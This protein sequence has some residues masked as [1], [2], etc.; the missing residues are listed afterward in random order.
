MFWFL[1]KQVA[2]A[3]PP[4]PMMTDAELA[5]ALQVANDRLY[6]SLDYKLDKPWSLIPPVKVRTK[7]MGYGYVEGR[8]RALIV[9]ARVAVCEADDD[10]D[11][12]EHCVLIDGVPTLLILA[13]GRHVSVTVIAERDFLADVFRTAAL[14]MN[15][16]AE[17]RKM[18]D[19]VQRV[20][21][22]VLAK[23][24]ALYMKLQQEKA[25]HEPIEKLLNYKDNA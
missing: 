1:R 18:P 25:A 22:D 17:F 16:V 10:M 2:K 4:Q 13:R 24:H 19:P 14:P 8:T 20:M 3:V 21:N 15:N 6:W 23:I 5:V 9:N 12:T 11:F 7:F